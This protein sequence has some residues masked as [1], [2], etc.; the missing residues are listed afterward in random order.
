MPSM[1][2]MPP[3][4]PAGFPRSTFEVPRAGVDELL[5]V[6]QS[7]IAASSQLRY[8]VEPAQAFQEAASSFTD[9]CP[10][11]PECVSS[12]DQAE[13]R[14]GILGLAGTTEI[15]PQPFVLSRGSAL[16]DIGK[17]KPCAFVHRPVGCMD[18]ISCAFCH[19]CAPGEKKRRQKSKLDAVR[20]REL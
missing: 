16:H 4:P 11:S 12:T 10:R 19:L 8:R 17:C 1:S 3:P 20:R 14:F 7:G 13:D 9:M 5:L 15:P 6:H 2:S 18:G